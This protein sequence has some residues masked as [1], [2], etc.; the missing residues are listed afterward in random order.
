MFIIKWA[1]DLQTS[2]FF[3]ISDNNYP[4]A[5]A[6]ACVSNL[7]SNFGVQRCMWG[8]DFPW[9][10]E[11]CGYAK[12]WDI[13]PPGFVSEEEKAW[14]EGGTLRSLFPLHFGQAPKDLGS[15]H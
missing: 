1:A 6:H 3:R 7:I 4:Y 11:K 15:I 2:A 12:A 5:D 10:T 9:V 8:S 13:L 14:L